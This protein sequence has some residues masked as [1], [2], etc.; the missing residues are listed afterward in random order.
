[1]GRAVEGNFDAGIP[2]AVLVSLMFIETLLR[3]VSE[4][5]CVIICCDYQ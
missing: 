2:I 4:R 3:I 1:M 5:L